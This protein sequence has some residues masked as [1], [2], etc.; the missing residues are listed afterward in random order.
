[1][2]TYKYM[3]HFIV[4]SLPLSKITDVICSLKKEKKP[5][6]YVLQVF[7]YISQLWPFTKQVI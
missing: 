5:M 4:I 6:L 1:M 2:W 7:C 3:L